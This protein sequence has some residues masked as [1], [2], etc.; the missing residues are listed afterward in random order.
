MWWDRAMRQGPK[1]SAAVT[2]F[3]LITLIFTF[4]EIFRDF[5]YGSGHERRPSALP[6]SYIITADHVECKKPRAESTF[7]SH[8]KILYA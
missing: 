6:A 7:P 8:L 2:L 4:F 3:V 1:I 5:R